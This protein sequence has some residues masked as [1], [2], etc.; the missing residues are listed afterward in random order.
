VPLHNAG[1]GACEASHLGENPGCSAGPIVA[2]RAALCTASSSPPKWTASIRRRGLRMSSP[3][4][5]LIRLKTN[6]C[7]GIGRRHLRSPLAQR[8]DHPRQQGPSRRHHHQSRQRPLAKVK[9]G[10]GI[11]PTRWRSKMASSGSMASEKRRSGVHR[12]RHRQPDGAH[13]VYKENPWTTQAVTLR[14]TSNGS[15]WRELDKP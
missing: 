12:L 4:S 5:P 3:G 7:P 8:H 14:A 6:F 13:Q 11:S 2:D 9:I 1:K 15:K 10:C